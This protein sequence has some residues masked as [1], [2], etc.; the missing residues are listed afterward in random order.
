MEE[1]I[2][3]IKLWVDKQDDTFPMRIIKCLD[4]QIIW[5]K[6]QYLHDIQDGRDILTQMYLT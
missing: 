5:L 4:I 3:H 6:S 1:A 2:N